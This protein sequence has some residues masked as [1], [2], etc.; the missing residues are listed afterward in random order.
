ME[1]CISQYFSRILWWMHP[2]SDQDI[3]ASDFCEDIKYWRYSYTYCRSYTINSYP[4]AWKI[5]QNKRYRETQR[6][7]ISWYQ[8]KGVHDYIVGIQAQ[9]RLVNRK[10]LYPPPKQALNFWLQAGHGGGGGVLCCTHRVHL[11]AVNLWKVYS[12]MYMYVFRVNFEKYP[13][14][15]DHA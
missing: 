11:R 10:K 3:I 12:I 1:Q 14:L 8:P 5:V 13:N 9:D 2:L 15:P 4:P 6:R 7:D